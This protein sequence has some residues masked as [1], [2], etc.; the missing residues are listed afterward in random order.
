MLNQPTSQIKLGQQLKRLAA[1]HER[2]NFMEE[3]ERNAETILDLEAEIFDKEIEISRV[4][5][6]RDLLQYKIED[7]DTEIEELWSKIIKLEEEIASRPSP[8]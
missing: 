6:E 1:L 3:I 5:E 8:Q 2:E 7:K 4:E